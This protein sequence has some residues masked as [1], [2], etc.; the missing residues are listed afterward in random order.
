MRAFNLSPLHAQKSSWSRLGL[1]TATGNKNVQK[2]RRL[3]QKR[4]TCFLAWSLLRESK[5]R[6]FS[7][8]LR[9]LVLKPIIDC[10]PFYQQRI[11][12]FCFS[13]ISS[14]LRFTNSK[15]KWAKNPILTVWVLWVP[16]ACLMQPRVGFPPALSEV[17]KAHL[18][19]RT[20][21]IKIDISISLFI[22]LS[23]GEENLG[24]PWKPYPLYH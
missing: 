24:F 9:S 17:L 10:F 11:W 21:H 5:I 20:K 1:A 3:S 13:V 6:L 2:L 7:Y 4:Q 18:G 22:P 8:F 12:H 14:S 23:N 16:L 19:Q 15:S